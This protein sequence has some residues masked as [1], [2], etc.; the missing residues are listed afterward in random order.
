MVPRPVSIPK[1]TI[2]WLLERNEPSVR[3]YTLTRLIGKSDRDADAKEARAQIGRRGWAAKILA[4]QKERTWWDN[5]SHC[6]IPKYASCVWNLIVLA[7]LGMTS[8]DI[9]ISRA[10]EHFMNLHNVKSGGFSLRPAGSGRHGP[11]VCLTGNMVASCSRLGYGGD[12]RVTRAADWLVSQQLPDGGWNC[13]ARFGSKHGSF[14]STIEPL[15][16]L[17]EAL[18]F[19]D[20]S[21]WRKSAERGAE[22]LLRHRLYRS[23]STGSVVMLD[24]TKLH[25]PLHYHYDIL[26][27]LRV[28]HDLGLNDD[29]RLDDPLRL[30]LSKRTP[31]GRWPLEGAY[32]GWTHP[33]S[34]DGDNVKRPEEEEVVERGWGKGRTLQFEEAGKPSKWITMR[35]IIAL[36]GFSRVSI[37]AAVN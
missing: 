35:A 7:D 20:K 33:Q 10:C 36:S 22:F 27:A 4:R 3:Y 29:P 6:Y 26:H 16:G 24:F 25:Y 17:A 34:A 11:H 37:P 23:E 8:G 19:V 30:L 18:K 15:W 28:L 31:Q 14:K 9:R 21:E 32:R 2:E 1:Q 12:A 13:Y 5:P